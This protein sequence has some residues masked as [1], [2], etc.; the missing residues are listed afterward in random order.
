ME[1]QGSLSSKLEYLVRIAVSL[2]MELPRFFAFFRLC[3]ECRNHRCWS[4]TRASDSLAVDDAATSR[5]IVR[6]EVTV[7]APMW[8]S[9]RCWDH[10]CR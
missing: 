2:K 7:M 10:R 5:G 3:H 8:Q 4:H 9:R 1:A 6:S